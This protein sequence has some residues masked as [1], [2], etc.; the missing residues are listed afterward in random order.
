M[1][2]VM[3]KRDLLNL[4]RRVKGDDEGG[5]EEGE[6]GSLEANGDAGDEDDEEE[7]VK[8]TYKVRVRVSVR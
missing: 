1:V 2:R 7:S 6:A 8:A 4:K 3:S 5:K